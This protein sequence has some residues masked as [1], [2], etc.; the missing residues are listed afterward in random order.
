MTHLEVYWQG[1][2]NEV[3]G[4]S[5]NQ[6]TRSQSKNQNT[7]SQ[8]ENETE[9]I[10]MK[11]YEDVGNEEKLELQE[12]K[13]KR[14]IYFFNRETERQRDELLTKRSLEAERWRD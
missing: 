14:K 8:S 5:E 1:N 13:E 12:K 2:Y 11:I 10:E 3:E 6:N 4:R 7:Q 9:D